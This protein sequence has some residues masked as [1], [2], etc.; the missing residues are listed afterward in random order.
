MTEEAHLAIA[1]RRLEERRV[2]WTEVDVAKDDVVSRLVV[3]P[4]YGKAVQLAR[5][6]NGAR[7]GFSLVVR[8]GDAVLVTHV[9]T[10]LLS[11]DLLAV[12]FDVGHASG[13]GNVLGA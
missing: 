6:P 12:N 5:G 3:E 4:L 13:A 9:L 11:T 8:N 10:D 2:L 7:A 1:G